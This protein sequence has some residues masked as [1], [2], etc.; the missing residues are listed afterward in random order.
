VV[1]RAIID[2]FLA[3]KSLG[4]VG[5]SRTGKG[6]GNAIRKELAARGYTIHL[7]HPEADAIDGQ[8]CARSLRDV[9][10]K[11]GGVVLVTP[12]ASTEKLVRQAAEAGVRRVWLQ[13]GA[14]SSDAIGF[15]E[16]EGIDVV[17]HE[18]I[19]MFAEPAG[20]PHGLHRWLRKIFGRMPR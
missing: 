18:C 16:R 1:T 5:V 17:H 12:P 2:D 9:A 6:F 8:S 3:H 7:V 19:L 20:F 15:C 14:E 10:D 11:V 13:Q 4:L